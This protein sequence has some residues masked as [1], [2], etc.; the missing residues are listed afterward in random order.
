MTVN[1][2]DPSQLEQTSAEFKPQVL[3]MLD[4]LT[5]SGESS[6]QLAAELEAGE[7]SLSSVQQQKYSG[8]ITH[9]AWGEVLE[10]LSSEDIELLIRL[11]TLAEMNLPGWEAG[12][13]SCVVPMVRALKDRQCYDSGLTRWIKAHTNN[14]FLPHGNLMDLL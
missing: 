7:L 14:K 5:D 4:E 10:V 2:F 1:S 13:K 3:A 6:M 12:A 9:P 8:M 11:F